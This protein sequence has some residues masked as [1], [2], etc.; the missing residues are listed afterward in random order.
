MVKVTSKDWQ[1]VVGACLT[2]HCRANRLREKKAGKLA[3]THLHKLKRLPI[4]VHI[5]W[6]GVTTM[7][8][9]KTHMQPIDS[10]YCKF[11][12]ALRAVVLCQLFYDTL[13][14]LCTYLH[15]AHVK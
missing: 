14:R 10:Y 9:H 6:H 5:S 11:H 7:T 8:A 15:H 4:S 3:T 2:L 13:L 12:H 1:A